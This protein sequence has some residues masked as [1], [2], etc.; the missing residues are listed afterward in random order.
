MT[1]F[2]RSL[3]PE[4]H[5]VIPSMINVLTTSSTGVTLLKMQ[6]LWCY[7]TSRR[8]RMNLTRGSKFAAKASERK[9]MKLAKTHE[10]KRC[11]MVSSA[12]SCLCSC[13]GLLN[14]TPLLFIEQNEQWRKK[15]LP[16]ILQRTQLTKSTSKFN[17]I[18]NLCKYKLQD[19]L[20]TGIISLK[21]KSRIH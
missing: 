4:A 19:N 18:H 13:F 10:V 8:K 16:A 5:H 20:M 6:R 11:Q 7:T 14:I 15:F 2:L 1:K 12:W 9:K 17:L 3:A 21:T